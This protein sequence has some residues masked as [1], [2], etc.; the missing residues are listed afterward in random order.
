MHCRVIDETIQRMANSLTNGI[1]LDRSQRFSD[2]CHVQ[3]STEATST[4]FVSTTPRATQPSTG[5]STQVP[6]APPTSGTPFPPSATPA[7]PGKN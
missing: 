6:T 3:D 5:Q 4:G 1:C 7:S 2:V